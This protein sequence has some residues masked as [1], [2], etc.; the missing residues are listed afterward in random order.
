MSSSGRIQRATLLL[1]A[2]NLLLIIGYCVTFGITISA[3]YPV[4]QNVN[5]LVELVETEVAGLPDLIVDKIGEVGVG[6]RDEIVAV[7]DSIS[8]EVVNLTNIVSDGIAD[9]D[10]R[11]ETVQKRLGI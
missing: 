2:M 1:T 6:M 7:G 9:I 10:D 5:G 4:V 8:D 11:I 3:I